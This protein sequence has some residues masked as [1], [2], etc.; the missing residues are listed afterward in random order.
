[1]PTV[2]VVGDGQTVVHEVTTALAVTVV[3]AAT[4]TTV[5]LLLTTLV[6]VSVTVRVVGEETV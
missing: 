6:E 5:T 2:K 4:A 1:M 3:G